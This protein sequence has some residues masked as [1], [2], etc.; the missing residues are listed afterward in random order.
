MRLTQICTDPHATLQTLL[1]SLE[2]RIYRV[3]W[4]R[5]GGSRSGIM[6][7]GPIYWE[8]ARQ[9]LENL[10]DKP[11]IEVINWD[12]ASHHVNMTA[13]ARED[14]IG[15]LRYPAFVTK[16]IS[17]LPNRYS[18]H[19]T[20]PSVMRQLDDFKQWYAF[21]QYQNGKMTMRTSDGK[22]MLTIMNK[23]LVQHGVVNTE[24]ATWPEVFLFSGETFF[25]N[26]RRTGA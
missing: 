23:I 11:P 25:G 1:R 24:F 4:Y 5:S 20:Q 7:E 15:S 12:S 17:L 13:R 22:L 3:P 8:A 21:T 19:V 9:K 26:H 18:V 10:Q 2:F 14:F 16:L 6:Y